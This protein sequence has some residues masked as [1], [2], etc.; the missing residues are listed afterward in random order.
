MPLAI[1]TYHPMRVDGNDAA[2]NDLV[3]FSEDLRAIA[4]RGWRV[5]PLREAV[6]AWLARPQGPDAPCVA[7]TCDDGSDFDFA[8]LPH[9][10]WGPQRGIFSRACAARDEGLPV[11][12][13]TFAIVSPAARAA[14][15][16]SCMLGRGWWNDG[17]WARATASGLMYVASHSWDHNHDSLPAGLAPAAERGTFESIDRWDLAEREIAQAQDY[18]RRVAPNPGDALF[19]YPYGKGN[20]YLIDDYLPRRAGALGLVAA[21]AD[22]PRAVRPDDNRWNLPRFIH[23]RDWSTPADLVAMLEAAFSA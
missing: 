4:A 18:L 16:R 2:S 19:A 7:L 22:T 20:A 5:V 14:L 10:T 17:W 15:D 13:T 8:D 1:L 12:V 21:F 9:P 3:A 6:E 11:H 23:A